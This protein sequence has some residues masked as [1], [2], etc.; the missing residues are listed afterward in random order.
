MSINGRGSEGRK[1]LATKY[2]TWD[3]VGGPPLNQDGDDRCCCWKT[4]MFLPA[5][6]AL[7]GAR[8]SRITS[9]GTQLNVTPPN[10]THITRTPDFGKID[11]TAACCTARKKRTDPPIRARIRK[12]GSLL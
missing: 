7:R 11:A 3:N 9:D 2:M 8:R 6:D 1:V 12:A 5:Y 10:P 4:R